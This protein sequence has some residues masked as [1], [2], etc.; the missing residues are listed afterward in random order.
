MLDVGDKAPDFELLKDTGDS[1]SL[2]EL[3]TDSAL[4]LFFY[5]ADFT[6]G[7]TAEA[8]DIRD[9]YPGIKAANASVVGVSPQSIETHQRFKS[10]FRL[11]FPLLA[12]PQKVA[13]KS[14]GVNGPLGFGVRRVTFL[15]NQEKRIVDRVVADFAIKRHR[16]F[17]ENVLDDLGDY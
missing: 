1:V 13:I 16:R 3:L 15:I 9:I 11:P 17:V 4:I 2:D 10:A 12:D 7:C 6:P 14:F 8:C 5:P